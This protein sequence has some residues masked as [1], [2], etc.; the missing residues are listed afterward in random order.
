MEAVGLAA[1]AAFA[2]QAIEGIIKLRA[3]FNDVSLA[4]RRTADLL[5]DMESLENTLLD[6]QQLIT[7]L[8]RS[9]IEKLDTG[10]EFNTSI[11]KSH[12][13]ACAEDIA[14]WVKV[15][16]EADPR[17]EK[18]LKA[19]FKKVKIAADKSG[20]AELGRKISTH[21]QRIGIS[22]SVLGRYVI[23]FLQEYIGC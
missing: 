12:L 8:E 20:F 18:G 13:K 7:T 10:A 6:I 21:R 11:L 5:G 17:S 1:I 9:S 2:G 14:L 23:N 15:T 19:F 22:L 4:P 16:R 3:F